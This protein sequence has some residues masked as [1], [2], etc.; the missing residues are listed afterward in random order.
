MLLHVLIPCMMRICSL[1]CQPFE[2]S[3]STSPSSDEEGPAGDEKGPSQAPPTRATRS[4][5]PKLTAIPAG[6]LTAALSG[7][8][9]LASV[10]GSTA[11]ATATPATPPQQ[12]TP[13]QGIFEPAAA[14][15]GARAG[16]AFK[17]GPLGL[18]YYAEGVA[19]GTGE[20]TGEGPANMVEASSDSD[21]GGSSGD[22]EDGASGVVSTRQRALI[23]RAFAGDDVVAEFAKEK[24]LRLYAAQLLCSSVC[25][26]SDD[27]DIDT[28][29][30]LQAAEVDA[31]HP[32]PETPSLLPG[33]GAW[34]GQRKST[35]A[36][37][38]AAQNK[39]TRCVVA[40]AG[41]GE[42]IHQVRINHLNHRVD[43]LDGTRSEALYVLCDDDL[44]ALCTKLVVCTAPSIQTSQGAGGGG[45]AAQGCQA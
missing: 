34:A 42:E 25:T 18:G 6:A 23:Q 16:A 11:P 22:S 45:G 39:A 44:C 21:G 14:F 19:E 35:P 20:G 3:R 8:A 38:T 10:A 41:A 27:V 40:C 13:L 2:R 12:P 17:R 32:M 31:E 29:S 4:R 24:V 43:N 5:A 30:H 33:W 1:R 28:T 37:I 15:A 7:A 9:P 36:W 26:C